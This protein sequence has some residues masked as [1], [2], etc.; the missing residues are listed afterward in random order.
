[1]LIKT[2]SNCVLTVHFKIRIK[3]NEYMFIGDSA[4]LNKFCIKVPN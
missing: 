1:M 4:S 2:E 3:N